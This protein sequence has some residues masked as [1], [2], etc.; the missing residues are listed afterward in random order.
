M[1]KTHGQNKDKNKIKD[2]GKDKEKDKVLNWLTNISCMGKTLPARV[3][4]SDSTTPAETD[5]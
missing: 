3:S 2:K 4:T 1:G 5:Q